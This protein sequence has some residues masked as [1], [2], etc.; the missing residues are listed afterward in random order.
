MLCERDSIGISLEYLRTWRLRQLG[1][2]FIWFSQEQPVITYDVI[3]R[4]SHVRKVQMS[5]SPSLC[6]C[7]LNTTLN[8]H[9]N[10]LSEKKGGG[11]GKKTW[12]TYEINNCLGT[13]WIPTLNCK[14]LRICLT[15]FE[16]EIYVKYKQRFLLIQ[17][18]TNCPV[19]T[20]NPLHDRVYWLQL[21]Y[22]FKWF[23]LRVVTLR[24][25]GNLGIYNKSHVRCIGFCRI[26]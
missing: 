9:K 25:T 18:H 26:N 19:P 24:C 14:I 16:K 21:W 15:T 4:G 7:L 22:K 17:Y 11:G 10:R 1:F 12:M 20:A 3:T 13:E 5:T 23:I 6:K 8:F 2:W